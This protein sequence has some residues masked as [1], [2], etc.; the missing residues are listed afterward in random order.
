MTS[1]LTVEA[2]SGWIVSSHVLKFC[3]PAAQRVVRPWIRP[4][5]IQTRIPDTAQARRSAVKDD[6]CGVQCGHVYVFYYFGVI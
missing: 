4:A 6:M 3:T 5:D 2:I 1:T